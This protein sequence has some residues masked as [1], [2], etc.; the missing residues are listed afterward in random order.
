VTIATTSA[1]L[2]FRGINNK[3]E[4]QRYLIGAEGEFDAFGKTARWDI[5]GQY[6]R[7]D[8][9]EQLRD[10]QNI[11]RI[12]AARDAALHRRAALSHGIDTVPDQRRC[13]PEQQRSRMRAA[14]PPRSRRRQSAAID[15]VL[16]DPR[17]D[18]V[19]EQTV[20]GVNFSAT[21]FATWA[22][23]VSVAIGAEYRK[24]E[25]SGFVPD[26]FQPVPIRDAN[27]NVTGATNR[28]SVGNY[29][30]SF[31]S[32]DVKEAYLETVVPLGLGLE[33]NG[34]CGRPTIQPQVTSRHGRWAPLG[35]RSM[36]SACVPRVRVT[37]GRLTST[38]CSR[39]ARPTATRSATLAS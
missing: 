37:S 34:A 30:P 9:R 12:N 22:G 6:G 1:D 36:I 17:R 21:P 8:L 7:A 19:L 14:E 24:E 11:A 13:Q 4:V 23:D 3:R 32:F 25:V 16:G 5:Y 26:E 15:Y 10:I 18:Q 27:G 29:L 2:P 35:S 31:G 38:I 28:F 20:A 33:V 39:Q